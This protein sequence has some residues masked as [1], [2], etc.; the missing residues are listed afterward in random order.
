MAKLR[1]FSWSFLSDRRRKGLDFVTAYS[2]DQTLSEPVERTSD[3]YSSPDLQSY[4]EPCANPIELPLFE[5]PSRSG[6]RDPMYFLETSGR[7]HFTPRQACAIESA[8]RDG[9]F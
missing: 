8:A 5:K 9:N 6:G 2:F 4:G 3:Y 7:D 1:Q